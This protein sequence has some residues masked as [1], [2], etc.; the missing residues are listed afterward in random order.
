MNLSPEQAAG[1]EK[2]KE[3]FSYAEHERQPFRLFGA[4]GTG[5]TT[6]AKYVPIALGLT[7]PH[8]VRY[9]TYT[10]KAAHVLRS[11]GA[12][13]VS[14]IHSGI[15]I[16]GP[17]QDAVK[18]LDDAR[19]ER[20]SLIH[21]LARCPE[22]SK[23][24]DRRLSELDESLPDL[25]KAARSVRFHWNPDSVWREAK[26]IILDEVSMV[27]PDL[28]RD[29]EAYGVP[30]LVL[31]DPAQLPPVDGGGYYTTA[32]PD[33]LLDTVH[34][35]ALKSPVLE[36]ATRVRRARGASLGLERGDFRKRSLQEAKEADQV[37]CWTNHRRWAMVNAMRGEKP[38]RLVTGD[39]IMCLTNNQEL[40]VF[41]GQQFTVRAD[42][43]QG[44]LIVQDDE[45]DE[46]EINVYASGFMG[47]DEQ[48][49]AK[50][51]GAG[52][53]GDRMLATYAQAIT[54]HKSQG[55]EWPSIYIVNEL[56]AMISQNSAHSGELA[57][58][59]AA[60]RWA[61]TAISRASESVTIT[62]PRR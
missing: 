35:Q 34:R 40:G 59:R 52:G 6:L 33:H 39:K 14:T 41:N 36:L 48:V 11:K 57:A 31:G 62:A 23:T 56:D 37:L 2:I 4:A 38:G 3:W 18:A 43:G 20:T 17:D 1:L 8:D 24:I 50:N 46:R 26:L 53:R 19:A 7:G 21:D 45:G 27:G 22:G 32:A 28:A 12:A 13:P 61:Y 44:S 5:K 15:Y 25:E 42:R 54:V 10:G 51:S 9:A 16:P 49:A 47:Q 60:R 58:Y 30:V 55:S 29:I